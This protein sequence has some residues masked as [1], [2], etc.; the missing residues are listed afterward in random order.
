MDRDI[1]LGLMR[2]FTVNPLHKSS[3]DS[4]G[5]IFCKR[6]ERKRGVTIGP[7]GGEISTAL[8]Q[9]KPASQWKPGGLAVAYVNWLRPLGFPVL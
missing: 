8:R 1:P 3:M 2:R 6:I 9:G 5:E 4:H 7:E